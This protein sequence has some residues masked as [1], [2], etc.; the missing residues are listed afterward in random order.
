MMSTT[1][2]N[3]GITPPILACTSWWVWVCL[4]TS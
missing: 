1:L 2:L 3:V 4:G